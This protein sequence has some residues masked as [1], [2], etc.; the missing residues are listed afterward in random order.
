MDIFYI[1]SIYF[2]YLDLFLYDPL[3]DLLNSVVFYVKHPVTVD[4]RGV[5]ET[6]FTNLLYLYDCCGA[7]NNNRLFIPS[8]QY[9]TDVII[10]NYR[11]SH[12]IT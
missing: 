5:T 8:L 6:R 2:F 1:Y 4:S 9:C 11:N 7:H 3:L 10:L 12:K